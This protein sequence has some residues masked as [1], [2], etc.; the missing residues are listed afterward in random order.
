MAKDTEWADDYAAE[1]QVVADQL[2]GMTISSAIV[3]AGN[4]KLDDREQLRLTMT[5]GS[6]FVVNATYGGYTGMS[7]DEYPQLIHVE[8]V[9]P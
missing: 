6:E 5:D 7:E 1:Q 8:R 9:T 2:V 3:K 4:P